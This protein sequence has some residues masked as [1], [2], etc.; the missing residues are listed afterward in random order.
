[1]NFLK[2]KANKQMSETD[3]IGCWAI[4]FIIILIVFVQFILYKL[5]D[6]EH[7]GCGECIID[8]SPI[9]CIQLCEMRKNK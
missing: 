6:H 1:M 9:S 2:K 3:N 7:K 8:D 5:L 4:I